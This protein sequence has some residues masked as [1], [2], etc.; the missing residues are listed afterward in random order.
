MENYNEFEWVNGELVQGETVLW[1]GKPSKKIILTTAEVL[2]IVLI[3][4]WFGFILA[5]ATKYNGPPEFRVFFVIFMLLGFSMVFGRF[6]L[7]KVCLRTTYYVIT[8]KRA[9][10][11]RKGKCISCDYHREPMITIKTR[12][13]GIGTITFGQKMIQRTKNTVSFNSQDYYNVIEFLN[14]PDA[15]N[16]YRIINQQ[17]ALTN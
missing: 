15:Q 6:I 14:I 12:K 16:V 1:R 4:I 11:Y 9:I 8:D 13:D 3:F 2:M 7:Q 17:K 5:S 10:I